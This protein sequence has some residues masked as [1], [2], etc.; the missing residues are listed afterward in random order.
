[1]GKRK[2]LTQEE[3]DVIA[4]HLNPM[5]EATAD[6][7]E[8]LPKSDDPIAK[9]YLEGQRRYYAQTLAALKWALET[10]KQRLGGGN[11]DGRKAV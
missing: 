1:M 10:A 9:K 6:N 11:G 8:R 7:M 3:L 2:K 4:D 5:I